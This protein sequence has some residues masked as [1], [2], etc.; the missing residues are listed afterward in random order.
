MEKKED[1]VIRDEEITEENRK[2]KVGHSDRWLQQ[3]F[4][5]WNYVCFLALLET[6]EL[7]LW[8]HQ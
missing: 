4:A 2:K 5:L 8:L 1:G 7:Y 3:S 6:K